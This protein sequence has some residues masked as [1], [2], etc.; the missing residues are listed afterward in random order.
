MTTARS[1]TPPPPF[2]HSTKMSSS[3]NI[4]PTLTLSSVN[5]SSPAAKSRRGFSGT[6]VLQG[7]SIVLSC[8]FYSCRSFAG[9]PSH[10][11][12][13]LLLGRVSFLFF[14]LHLL[15]RRPVVSDTCGFFHRCVP[16]V[17]GHI[18]SPRTAPC[19]P[20]CPSARLECKSCRRRPSIFSILGR[21][22]VSTGRGLAAD[23]DL[24]PCA[25][26]SRFHGIQVAGLS[27]LH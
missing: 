17:V 24:P 14:S 20:G 1:F 8:V 4:S 19:R 13:L 25:F 18:C 7:F 23:Y 10:C 21:C 3:K 22:K 27:R 11:S 2:P 6:S 12:L 5:S 15:A 16:L 9:V 26:P